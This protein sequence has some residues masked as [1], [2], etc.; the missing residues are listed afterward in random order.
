[1]Y[2]I[3]AWLGTYCT[4]PERMLY[5]RV[6]TVFAVVKPL[7]DD[8]SQSPSPLAGYFFIFT[9]L[10]AGQSLASEPVAIAECMRRD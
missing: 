9:L 10:P 3:V 2:T 1:M 4:V 5:S 8:P 6:A 7:R